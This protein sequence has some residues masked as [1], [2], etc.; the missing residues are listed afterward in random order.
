MQINLSTATAT[1]ETA[2]FQFIDDG[3]FVRQVDNTNIQLG[4]IPN[5]GVII[6]P[7]ES[8]ELQPT[9]PNY[10]CHDTIDFDRALELLSLG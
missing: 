5:V 3:C 1:L 4:E 8:A 2:G 9:A 10:L 7:L 6:R